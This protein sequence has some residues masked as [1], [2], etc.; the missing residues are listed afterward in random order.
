MDQGCVV[1]QV[2]ITDDLL[3]WTPEGLVKRVS[4]YLCGRSV[5]FRQLSL[6]TWVSGLEEYGG[7][8]NCRGCEFRRACS[9]FC[10]K[11]I[12]KEVVDAGEAFDT[13]ETRNERCER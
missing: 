6:A 11:R 1:G 12:E 8:V 2:E 4:S 7:G 10:R 9:A 5:E 13:D 3:L